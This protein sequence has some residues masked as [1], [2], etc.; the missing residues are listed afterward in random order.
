MNTQHFTLNLHKISVCTVSLWVMIQFVIVFIY[1][2]NDQGPDQ[3]GYIR[4][5]LQCF[6]FGST[7]P[8]ALNI[9]DQYLQS[10]GMVN[11]LM[12]Q[13][14][15]FGTTTFSIDKIFNIFLNIGIL[16][17]LFILTKRLF[18]ERTAYISV[19]IY[20]LLPTNLFAPIWI[21]TELPYLF[22]ALTGFNLSL[23]SKGWVI[24][25]AS[26][27]YGLAH[28]F[29]PLVLAF[30]LTSIVLFFVE[31]RSIKD[32]AFITIP[33]LALLLCI[34]LHN[35][36]NTGYFVT[37]STTGG[38]NLIMT[39]NDRAMA[40][41]EFSIFNDTTNIAYIPN[42]H[43]LSFAVKDSVYKARATGWIATH[44]IKYFTLYL[45]K[46]GRLWAGDTWSMPKFSQW[47]DYDYIRTLPNPGNRLLIR[48]F[49]QAIEGL[50][51]YILVVFFFLSIYKYRKDIFSKKGL[52]L[53]ILALGTAGTCLFTVE[54]RFHYP[55]LFCLTVWAAHGIDRTKTIRSTLLKTIDSRSYFIKRMC[56]KI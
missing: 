47:D 36:S 4:H 5:A 51:Y 14:I 20:C 12:L 40:R 23:G 56:K 30:L 10:P 27:F 55:Y 48:R 15:L 35:K 49:I 31:R 6:E 22:L 34:G 26:V 43:T 45:E 9:Y 41:P 52:I 28:P 44:P 53:L 21:L 13:H 24:I 3:Q 29:R 16:F 42:R 7:Y 33:Y 19:I 54:V 37:S 2:N 38:Y 50:P 25:L 1:W 39:A 46:I 11:Y 8:S 18:N 17:N 32:Y